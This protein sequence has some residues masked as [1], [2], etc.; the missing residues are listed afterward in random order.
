MYYG[1]RYYDATL[2]RFVQ[3]DTVVPNPG[4]PQDLNRYA[5]VRNNPLRYVDPSGHD[6]WD[7][8]VGGGCSINDLAC[9]A[10]AGVGAYKEAYGIY[11]YP[12]DEELE[13]ACAAGYNP[14]LD[15][16]YAGASIPAYEPYFDFYYRW[17]YDT[18]GWLPL[19]GEL[20]SDVFAYWTFVQT[21]RSAVKPTDWKDITVQVVGAGAVL[22]GGVIADGLRGPGGGG[23]AG[24]TAG[25][26]E[27]IYGNR[28][29]SPKPTW[30]YKLVDRGTGQV[31]KYGITNATNPQWRYTQQWYRQNNVDL[32]PIAQGQ[33]W[34]MYQLEYQLNVQNNSPWSVHGH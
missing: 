3:A 11:G 28:L 26:V 15:P 14:F 1:A 25:V 18:G 9:L 31:M 27:P 7:P 10:Q 12:T 30:L 24:N 6:A 19:P 20:R 17:A 34:H 21:G 32:I 2:G 16:D 29:D 5:Y 22:F 8:G 23:D 4:N 33:R 13:A